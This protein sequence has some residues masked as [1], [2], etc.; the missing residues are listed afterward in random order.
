M[1]LAADT[2]VHIY[3]EYNLEDVFRY[4]LRNLEK[5]AGNAS[6]GASARAIFLVERSGFNFF[7]DL[8]EGKISPGVEFRVEESPEEE[9]LKIT[10]RHEGADPLYVIA[11]R[12]LTTYE[13]LEVL[14]L[15][16][17]PAIEDGHAV[18][19]IIEAVLGYGA[20]AVLNWAPGKWLFQRGRIVR[21][22]IEQ[23]VPGEICLA[24]SA[25][26]PWG[27]PISALMRMGIKEGLHLLLGTDPFPFAGE[28][29]TIGTCG[30][31]IEEGFDPQEPVSSVRRLLRDPRVVVRRVGRRP[32]AWRVAAKL[33]RWH[34]MARVLGQPVH[35]RV[36]GRR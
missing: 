4:A 16:G 24:D 19:T 12:Q 11:G 33:W 29:R 31:L 35:G 17:R 27:V 18:G 36:G 34:R 26:R 20:V 8:R 6:E 5:A 14:A 15:A 3:P 25:L 30:V 7:D 10:R 1:R 23:S 28:E 32:P 13:G 2:H 21:R 9:C 22:L